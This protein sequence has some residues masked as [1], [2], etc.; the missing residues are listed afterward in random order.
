MNFY[1]QDA[2]TVVIKKNFIVKLGLK[3]RIRAIHDAKFNQN[4]Q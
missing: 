2:T 3:L 1:Q 4:D